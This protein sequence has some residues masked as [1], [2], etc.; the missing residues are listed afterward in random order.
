MQKCV[1]LMMHKFGLADDIMHRLSRDRVRGN[2]GYIDISLMAV[3]G[4]DV[5]EEYLE[6]LAR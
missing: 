1:L 6:V 2:Q 4:V 5:G 3:P